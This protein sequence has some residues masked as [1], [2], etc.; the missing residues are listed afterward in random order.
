MTAAT[1]FAWLTDLTEAEKL[2]DEQGKLVLVDFFS[3]A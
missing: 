1:A 3:P 2:A